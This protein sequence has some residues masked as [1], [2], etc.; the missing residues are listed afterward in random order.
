MRREGTRSGHK[1]PPLNGQ[2][3]TWDDVTT[4]ETSAYILVHGYNCR[5]PLTK[6]SKGGVFDR[7]GFLCRMESLQVETRIAAMD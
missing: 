3:L 7:P 4:E 2:R 6:R 1:F 5:C